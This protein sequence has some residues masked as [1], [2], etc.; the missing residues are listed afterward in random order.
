MVSK[1]EKDW[2][3]LRQKERGRGGGEASLGV[4][5]EF[6]SS[7]KLLVCSQVVLPSSMTTPYLASYHVI[8]FGHIKQNIGE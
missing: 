8:P 3:T 7:W 4:F 1:S 6:T 2:E 5:S